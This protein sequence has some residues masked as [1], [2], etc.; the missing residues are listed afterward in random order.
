[1]SPGKSRSRLSCAECGEIISDRTLWVADGGLLCRHCA[2]L[3]RYSSGL[4]G[5]GTIC[6]E[7]KALFKPRWNRD[8]T[9][10]GRLST[11]A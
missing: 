3:T 10:D 6:P 7:H 9:A 4:T 1:M 5:R 8:S 2:M 11:A